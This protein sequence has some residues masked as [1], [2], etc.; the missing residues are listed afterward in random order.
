MVKLVL[1]IK[2]H[3]FIEFLRYIRG[4]TS[5]CL[6][7]RGIGLARLA[8]V[9]Y[10]PKK[11][12]YVSNYLKARGIV[13]R[14]PDTID[15]VDDRD[16]VLTDDES[17]AREL[18]NRAS[19]V[20]Y[21][22]A[23]GRDI[24]EKAILA[25]KNKEQYNLLTI[26]VD[27][28]DKYTVVAIADG[29]LIE[30]KHIPSLDNTV[31]YLVN[32]VEQI[33][34]RKKEVKIGLGGNGPVLAY[35]VKKALGDKAVVE[36]IDE[37]KSTPGTLWRN[38]FIERLFLHRISGLN[39]VYKKKDIYAAIIIAFKNGFPVEVSVEDRDAEE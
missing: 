27:P 25:L 2:I 31:E 38:P 1:F 26:G 8:L 21:D 11:Y 39:Q 34:S 9:I 18:E 29:E 22:K 24:I 28:G 4:S 5:I 6:W 3:L 10:D 17:L 15:D 33:P 36:L 35:K 14:V 16:I 20:F 12:I 30:W 37:E 32:I 23:M 7:C 19:L 13:F